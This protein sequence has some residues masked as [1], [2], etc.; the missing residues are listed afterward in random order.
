I[1]LGKLLPRRLI[2]MLTS[3]FYDIPIL[4][5]LAARVVQCIRVP[6]SGYRHEAPELA[7]AVAALDRGECVL[8]F[9]E[10]QMRKREDRPLH[11]F[12]RGV[13][14]ILRQRPATPVVVCWIE[15]AWGSSTS[16]CNGPPAKTKRLDFWRPILV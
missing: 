6:V 3:D 2:A 14:H 4:H 11:R 5:F 8:V 15:G 10:G 7:E 16:Y 12:G 13:W 1:F 9:P